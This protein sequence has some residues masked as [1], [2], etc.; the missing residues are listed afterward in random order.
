MAGGWGKIAPKFDNCKPGLYN[1]A[2]VHKSRLFAI[3]TQEYE[4]ID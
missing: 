4:I 2:D 3:C 1:R